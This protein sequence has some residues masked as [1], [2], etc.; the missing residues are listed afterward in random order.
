MTDAAYLVQTKRIQRELDIPLLMPQRSSDHALHL[1]C[2]S[3]QTHRLDYCGAVPA[4]VF[5]VIVASAVR[6][7]PRMV[8]FR[9]SGVAAAC[10]MLTSM[11]ATARA[12]TVNLTFAAPAACPQGDDFQA[13]VR[14]RGAEFDGAGSDVRMLDVK[15]SASGAGFGGTLRVESASGKSHSR[16]SPART[17][18]LSLHPFR[19]TRCAANSANPR[20]RGA[21]V[22][23][24]GRRLGRP[25]R[26]LTP[27]VVW[28]AA[29]QAASFSLSP[30]KA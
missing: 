1:G 20:P 14:E 21:F 7:Y 17:R 30:M 26:F 2:A 24:R 29:K 5:F 12:E 15:V 3:N 9:R 19:A 18:S 10:L 27:I 25:R 16:R 28:K 13:A 22:M 23:K 6:D 8:R 11:A 4:V